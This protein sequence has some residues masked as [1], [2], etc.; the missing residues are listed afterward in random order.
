MRRAVRSFA[1]IAALALGACVPRLAPLAGAPA[2]ATSLPRTTIAPGHHKIVFDWTLSDQEMTGKGD[3]VARIAAPDS[4]RLDF[5]LAGGFGGGGAILIGDSVQ[6]PGGDM[7]RRLIPPPTLLWAALGRVALPNLP[8]TVIRVEGDVRRADIGNPVAW[9]LTFRGDTLR[10]V[11]RVSG[12]K[13]EEWVERSDAT[14]IQYRNERTRRSLQ[15]TIT[16]T[17][18]VPEFD[19]STWRLVR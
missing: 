9:R 13:V 19:A 18:E 15:L 5:F 17:E 14:H 8:D 6:A 1:G 12:G 10:R 11:D 3:G 2:P 4:A 16:R 7:I